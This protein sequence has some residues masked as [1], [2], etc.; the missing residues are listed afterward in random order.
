MAY[1]VTQPC[2]ADAS[3][4]LA[5]PV[6]CIHPAPGEPG[7]AEAEMVYIDPRSCVGCGACATACP[8]DAIK[9]EAALRPAEQVFAA[10]NAEY[11]DVFPHPDRTPLAVVG[12]QRRLVG[13]RPARSVRVAVVG[14]GPAG[15]YTADELLRHPEV[16]VD[17]LDRLPTPYGLLRAGV[18]PDHPHTKQAERLFAQIESQPGFRYLLGAEVGADLDHAELAARYDAVVYAVGA[19]TDRRL[20]LPGEDLRGSCSATEVV[21]WYNGQP[22]HADLATTGALDL[23]HH[24]VVVVGNGNVALDAARVLTASPERLAGTDIAGPAYDALA[25]SAVQ[26][27]VVLGRRGPAQAAF[28]LPEL[29]GLQALAETGEVDVVVDTG[30]APLGGSAVERVLAGLADA[31]RL[32]GRRRV[33]LRFLTAPRAVV[34]EDGHVTGL[35]VVRTRLVDDADGVPRAVPTDDVETIPTGTVLRSVG[36]HGRPVPGLPFDEATG[37]VPHERGRVAPG[38][39]VVGWIK[40]GPT[41][42]LGTNKTDAQ[43][44]VS[45]ILD[46]LD[47]GTAVRV[48]EVAGPTE[49]LHLLRGRGV[50][51]HSRRGWRAIDAEERRR[52]G[53]EGRTRSKI[54]RR[55]ELDDV[56][57][58]ARRRRRYAGR[59]R[60]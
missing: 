8:V 28:T 47:A 53:D 32:P 21:G 46:D 44:T 51:V 50:V 27:V 18:A 37:T 7:F 15:L 4:V 41:G 14:A 20:G 33:V 10:V 54:V 31:P 11:Y 58:G 3:C 5:C 59:P 57:S 38:T 30:G 52:G 55:V 36:Y 19:A 35:E 1:V 6:N 26:E 39:Y 60:R 40:R 25:R 48:G 16:A 43:E 9:P 29:L 56:A 12:R 13:D 17:V 22:D 24:R 42:F 45:T 23:G 34:G 2:C 49:L